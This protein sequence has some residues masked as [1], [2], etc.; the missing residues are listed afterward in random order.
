MPGIGLMNDGQRRP[1][2]V[3]AEYVLGT[4]DADERAQVE[5]MMSVN[6]EFKLVVE[7]WERRLGELHAMVGAV[8]PARSS[9]EQDPHGRH[10]DQA[11]VLRCGCRR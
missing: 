2:R 9:V 8:E 5:M 10:G 6:P 3:A 1:Y 11:G 7:Q 4:L